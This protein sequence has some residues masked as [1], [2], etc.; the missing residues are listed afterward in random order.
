MK[1][2]RIM[3]GTINDKESMFAFFSKVLTHTFRDNDIWDMQ[4]DLKE[5]IEEKEVFF[6]ESV[7][8]PE[9]SRRFLLAKLDGDL[10]GCIA[11]GPANDSI[12]EGSK[13]RCADWLEVG[14]VF[15]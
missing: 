8:E 13:G 12:I 10:I 3:D 1:D 5:E 9:K 11:I 4:D 15:V 14:T 6:M 7:L 2:I